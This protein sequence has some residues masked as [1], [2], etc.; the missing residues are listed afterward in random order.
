[1]KKEEIISNQIKKAKNL[2]KTLEKLQAKW[3][4]LS[5][6]NTFNAKFWRL[7]KKITNLWKEVNKL[8]FNNYPIRSMDDLLGYIEFHE[9]QLNQ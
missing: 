3:D 6:F 2:Y 9:L 4:I 7:D 1:M 5:E 8:A